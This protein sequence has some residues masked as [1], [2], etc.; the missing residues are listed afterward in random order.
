[1]SLKSAM[2]PDKLLPVEL[3]LHVLQHVEPSDIISLCMTCH[4]FQDLT[5]AHRNSL[6]FLKSAT[7]KFGWSLP[8]K[9]MDVPD[10]TMEKLKRLASSAW[11][12]SN[13]WMHPA[14]S[15]VRTIPCDIYGAERVIILPGGSYF[16]KV[17]DA[18]PPV[19][20]KVEPIAR[21]SYC[22]KSRGSFTMCHL[23]CSREHEI[24]ILVAQEYEIF[25]YSIDLT[26]SSPRLQCQAKFGA[27][28]RRIVYATANGDTVVFASERP[29]SVPMFHIRRISPRPMDSTG[30]VRHYGCNAFFPWVSISVSLCC[31]PSTGVF[32][33]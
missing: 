26:G 11:E 9:L 8:L 18:G 6:R 21:A 4:D 1:M 15:S 31:C 29:S 2:L 5:R 13:I 27:S 12:R 23:F 7:A 22:P 24:R 19:I 3:W 33:L 20:Q 10:M 32:A 14:V 28:G 17:Y 25:I 16:L 30:L